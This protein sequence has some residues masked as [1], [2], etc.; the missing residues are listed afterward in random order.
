MCD[1]SGRIPNQINKTCG[2]Y[3]FTSED[4]HHTEETEWAPARD[5]K[6]SVI[7]K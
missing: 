4:N 7:G 3:V 2:L 6:E 1:M 5:R